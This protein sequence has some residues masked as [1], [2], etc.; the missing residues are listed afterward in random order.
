M[1]RILWFF[2][3]F[4]GRYCLGAILTLT[5]IFSEYS[6]IDFLATDWTFFKYTSSAGVLLIVI[7]LFVHIIGAVVLNVK[8]KK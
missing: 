7:N 4:W 1:K 5:G 2:V 6:T 3:T 8:K